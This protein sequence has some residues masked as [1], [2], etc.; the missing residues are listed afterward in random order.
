[1]Y[2]CGLADDDISISRLEITFSHRLLF[3]R[4]GIVNSFGLV[5]L[6]AY[7]LGLFIAILVKIVT[8]ISTQA[9]ETFK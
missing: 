3:L 2:V 9:K 7:F 8:Y 5:F 6:I 4:Y 1:M